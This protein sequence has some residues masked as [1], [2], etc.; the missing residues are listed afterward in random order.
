VPT[1]SLPLTGEPC[2]ELPVN[3]VRIPAGTPEGVSNALLDAMPLP[4]ATREGKLWMRGGVACMLMLR[5]EPEPSGA[6]VG[7]GWACC[8]W[9]RSAVGW[10]R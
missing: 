4:E 6:A 10:V 9:R 5:V 2:A 8:T 7:K 1:P 3:V